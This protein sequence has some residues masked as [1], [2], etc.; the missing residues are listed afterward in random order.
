MMTLVITDHTGHAYLHNLQNRNCHMI[1]THVSSHRMLAT[2]QHARSPM[3][4]SIRQIEFSIII[5]T[6]TL[7]ESSLVIQQIETMR[8]LKQR[9]GF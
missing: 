1:T 7:P 3:F 8:K 2:C 6:L 5:V 9:F 4:V